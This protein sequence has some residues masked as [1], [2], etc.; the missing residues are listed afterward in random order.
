MPTRHVFISY[1]HHDKPFVERLAQHLRQ[2]GTDTWRDEKAAVAGRLE[3]QINDA[4]FEKDALLL[5]FSQHSCGSDWVEWEASR[6]REVEKQEGRDVLCP[7]AL[8]DAW[9]TT[10]WRGPLQFQIQDYNILDFSDPGRFD[11]IVDRLVAGLRS[12]Y[13]P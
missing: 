12:Y 4:I 10:T 8:D 2:E 11:E 3:R 1:S 13:G 6:A 7:I 5:V 9:K